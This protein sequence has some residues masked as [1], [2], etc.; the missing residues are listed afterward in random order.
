MAVRRHRRPRGHEGRQRGENQGDFGTEPAAAAAWPSPRNAH[1]PELVRRRREC[2]ELPVPPRAVDVVD[3]RHGRRQRSVRQATQQRHVGQQYGAARDGRR[4]RVVGQESRDVDGRR[5]RAA[6]DRGHEQPQRVSCLVVA[7]DGSRSARSRT[8]CRGRRD[9]VAR[10]GERQLPEW[11]VAGH[12]Q[13]LQP[14]E[15][16]PGARTSAGQRARMA[17]DDQQDPAE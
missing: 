14:R 16:P 10:R 11:V 12:A 8:R 17:A 6:H 4:H 7:G 9:H 15:R 3:R 1:A 13:S 5:L 2:R